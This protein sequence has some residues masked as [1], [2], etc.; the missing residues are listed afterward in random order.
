MNIIA[1]ATT[2]KF[3]LKSFPA[4]LSNGAEIKL[5]YRDLMDN[6]PEYVEFTATETVLPYQALARA[7]KMEVFDIFEEWTNEFC[8]QIYADSFC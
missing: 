7:T 3:A 4:K 6:L 8:N 2:T 5:Y 1:R